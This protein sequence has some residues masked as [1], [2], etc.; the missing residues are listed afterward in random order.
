VFHL[1]S[2][3]QD[4]LCEVAR[5]LRP[6][7]MLLNGWNSKGYDQSEDMLWKAWDRA[8][9]PERTA[10]V[11]VP[12]DQLSTFLPDSGWRQVGETWTHHYTT[13]QRPQW[14]L[15]ALEQRCWASLWKLTD[16]ELAHGLAAVRAAM[17]EHGIDPRQPREQAHVF[18]VE[19][20]LPPEND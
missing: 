7:G 16:A 13:L 2:G 5:M 19:A 20:F 8:M 18:K 9:Q 14:F 12:R 1:V 17:T 11:G 6:G 10:T 4:A 3:W 15:D